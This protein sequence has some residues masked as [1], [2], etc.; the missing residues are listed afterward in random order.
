MKQIIP[1]FVVSAF[2]ILLFSSFA[3]ASG[4]LLPDQSSS[5]M[6][7]AS[8]FAGQADDPSAVWYNPAGI[9]QLDGMRISGGVIAV[10]PSL[11]HENT[12]GITDVSKRDISLPL[13]FYAVDRFNDR[14]SLGFGINDPFGLS[15]NW[16]NTSE[17]RYVATLSKLT[18]V[19]FNPNVAYKINDNLSAAVG[20]GYLRL[21]ATLEKILASGDNFRLNGDG[22]GWGV[23]AAVLY[24]ASDR[25]NFGLS[26]RSKISVDVDGS[27]DVGGGVISNPGDTKIT[28]PDLIQFG[29][30]FKVSDNLTLNADMDYTRWATYDKLVIHSDTFLALGLGTDTITEE[31][32]W[33]DVWA[34]RIG[35]QYKLSEQWKVRS[36]VQF[37]Q[38]PVREEWFETRVP[39]SDR[40]GVSVGAGYTKGNIT[41]DAAYLYLHFR[42]R[43]IHNSLADGEAVTPLTP[44]PDALNGAYKSEAHV[45]GVTIGCTF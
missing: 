10:Y 12:D 31:K 45:L 20:I 19:E 43:T 28:L 7:M 8:A 16:S 21:R 27:V 33:Q 6:G 29:T 9:T 17:T 41:V 15:T 44:T 18:T 42:K 13:H 23:N 4:F 24:K 26:Y 22:Y 35:G 32:H 2:S 37:D 40:Q 30:S 1:S 39:D 3:Y 34:V 5:A 14:I 38:T 36:G 11:T 25:L